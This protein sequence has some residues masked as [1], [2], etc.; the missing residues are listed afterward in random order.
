[1]NLLSTIAS[2]SGGGPNSILLLP[3]SG[4]MNKTTACGSPSTRPI[5][6]VNHPTN[7]VPKGTGP[8]L[9]VSDSSAHLDPLIEVTTTTTV[10]DQRTRHTKTKYTTGDQ[11]Q[12]QQ[13]GGVKRNKR[14]KQKKRA[15]R[16]APLKKLE[17]NSPGGRLGAASGVLALSKSENNLFERGMKFLGEGAVVAGGGSTLSGY[18]GVVSSMR[19][20]QFDSVGQGPGR[21]MNDLSKTQVL[22]TIAVSTEAVG[23]STSCACDD[24]GTG[25]GEEAGGGGKESKKW[26]FVVELGRCLYF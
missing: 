24:L 22:N 7:S 1:M 17:E 14:N 2:S 20:L 12:Q 4:M 19:D 16:K 18:D 3:Q 23:F 25:L 15:N 6:S 26:Q 9:I 8:S 10:S 13:R 5:L 11:Q 21:A